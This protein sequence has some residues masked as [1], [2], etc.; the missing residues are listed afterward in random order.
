MDVIRMRDVKNRADT[1]KTAK[2]LTSSLLLSWFL[3]AALGRRI[4]SRGYPPPP[5]TCSSWRIVT[6][7]HA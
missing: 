6:D 5:S 2:S 1:Y 3:S 4:L 7:H